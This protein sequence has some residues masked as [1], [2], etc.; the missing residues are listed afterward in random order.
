MQAARKAGSCRPT[1]SM[2]AGL[3]KKQ[4]C[5]R[6]SAA[7]RPVPSVVLPSTRLGLTKQATW[8]E[9]GCWMVF[10][11]WSGRGCGVIAGGDTGVRSSLHHYP[12]ICVRCLAFPQ[13]VLLFYLLDNVLLRFHATQVV[14]CATSRAASCAACVPPYQRTTFALLLRGCRGGSSFN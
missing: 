3:G 13:H 12:S 10:Y 5:Y 8:S 11:A 4:G 9:L 1:L 7:S 14:P 6:G 2:K